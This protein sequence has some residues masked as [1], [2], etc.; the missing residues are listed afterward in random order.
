MARKDII[1]MTIKELERLRTVEDVLAGRMDERK[2]AQVMR[3]SVKQT[4]RLVN[5]VRAEGKQ[6][7]THKG[8][9]KPSTRRIPDEKK[10]EV[11]RLYKEHYS[12]FGPTLLAEKLEERDG[13]K[14]SAETLRQWLLEWEYWKRKR[15]H[16]GHRTW[17]PRKEC[18]GEMVQIDGCH[19]DWLEGRGPR[20][21]LMGYIDDATSTVHARFYNY[22]GTLPAMCS[23]KLYVSQ[24]GIPRSVYLDRHTTYKSTAKPTIEDDLAGRT[25]MSQF[26][27]ALNELGVEVI[28]AYSPQA[29]GRVERLFRTLQDRLVKEMRLQGV[30]TA[31]EANNFLETYLPKFNIK[32]GVLPASPTDIHMPIPAGI[33]L[34]DYLCIKTER[35]IMK[36]NTI[37]KD[38]KLYQLEE[39]AGRKK[40]IVEDR[41]DG[42]MVIKS[43]DKS[44]KYREIKERAPKVVQVS[45]PKKKKPYKPPP[46][47]PW[48]QYQP[49]KATVG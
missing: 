23:F 25:P 44:L 46:D 32:F 48:R 27:R 14:L 28:H 45:M 1:S 13:I 21:V 18:F 35:S 17:R 26:E 4:R 9:G 5:A 11:K 22:E 6:G 29:K 41:I 36:D 20:L 3:L 15:K 43:G 33:D 30:N 37:A 40:V 31:D 49:S 42:V 19:H 24:Y 12:D 47:H 39:S 7:I 2:A 16:R 8:R 38:R 34:D 10:V